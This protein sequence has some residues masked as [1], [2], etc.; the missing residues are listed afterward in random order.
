MLYCLP[1]LVVNLEKLIMRSSI[2]LVKL[3]V[4]LTQTIIDF[5]ASS[6]PIKAREDDY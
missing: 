1:F 4:P 3:S 5:R 2:V 6:T